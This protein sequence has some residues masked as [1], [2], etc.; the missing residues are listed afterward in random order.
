MACFW[1]AAI[2]YLIEKIRID[3][4]VTMRLELGNL[5]LYIGRRMNKIKGAS[6]HRTVP[7]DCGDTSCALCN[8]F[9]HD[10]VIK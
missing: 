1:I 8:G 9:G 6:P 10:V 3:L 7:S 2:S 5:A 4:N